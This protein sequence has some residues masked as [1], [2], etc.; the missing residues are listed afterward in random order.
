MTSSS[1]VD[2]T[3]VLSIVF[4]SGSSAVAANVVT[5]GSTGFAATTASSTSVAVAPVDSG[6][7]STHCWFAP[8]PRQVQPG[9]ADA[10]ALARSGAVT[11]T[12]T[13]FAASGPSLCTSTVY[14]IAWPATTAVAFA[15][16]VTARFA[17]TGTSP[18]QL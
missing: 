6:S 2:T 18:T 9:E 5:T 3:T 1:G 16:A 7:T 13:W 11:A 8:R 17:D 12:S 15:F 14:W 4:E 10:P